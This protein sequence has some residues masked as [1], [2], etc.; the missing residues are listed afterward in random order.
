M[1]YVEVWS[2][3]YCC[4]NVNIKSFTFKDSSIESIPFIWYVHNN[5]YEKIQYFYCFFTRIFFLLFIEVLKKNQH[6]NNFLIYFTIRE[7]DVYF[8]TWLFLAKC[9]MIYILIIIII[10]IRSMT[11]CGFRVIAQLHSWPASTIFLCY[12][13]MSE[14][15]WISQFSR[16]V[17]F[18]FHLKWYPVEWQCRHGWLLWRVHIITTFSW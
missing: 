16:V 10:I 7:S 6:E 18:F 17:W 15:V 5:L 14:S 8:S 4:E 13:L 12:A 1:F 9:N 2:H 3:I 11:G